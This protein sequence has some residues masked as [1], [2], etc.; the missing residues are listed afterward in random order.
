[1]I[2]IYS[3]EVYNMHLLGGMQYGY[4]Y[5]EPNKHKCTDINS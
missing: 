1:M 2:K 5:K 4:L 3:F